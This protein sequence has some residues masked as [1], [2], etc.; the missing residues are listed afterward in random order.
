MKPHT[1]AESVTNENL[2]ANPQEPGRANLPGR[3]RSLPLRPRTGQPRIFD[4]GASSDA[5]QAAG[6]AYKASRRVATLA[7]RAAKVVVAKR[8]MARFGG[9]PGVT[10]GLSTEPRRLLSPTPRC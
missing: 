9:L 1:T 7:L 8:R 10:A 2:Q 3:R 6:V 5:A 4:S